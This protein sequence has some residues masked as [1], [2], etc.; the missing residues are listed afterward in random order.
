VRDDLATIGIEHPYQIA[1]SLLLDE[2]GMRAF[3]SGAPL[4]TDDDPVLEHMAT[5][6]N[7]LYYNHFVSNLE[8]ALRHRPASPEKLVAGLTPEERAEFE[9]VWIASKHWY[10]AYAAM[11]R[12]N[13]T[14]D[15]SDL[16]ALAQSTTIAA[17]AATLAY[18]G[19]RTWKDLYARIENK[20]GPLSNRP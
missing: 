13:V 16:N 5:Y 19:W 10:E 6:H 1:A 11:S 7:Y 17:H 8:A 14:S 3:T 15:H 20:L 2:A 12:M 4:H 9:R 18:P